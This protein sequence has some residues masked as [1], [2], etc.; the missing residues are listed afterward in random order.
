MLGDLE[1]L[2]R[3]SSQLLAYCVAKKVEQIRLLASFHCAYARAMREPTE[4]NIAAQRSALDAVLSAGGKVGSSLHI[5]NLVEVSLIAG[6]WE[7]AEAD[8]AD[9]FAFV[10]QSGERYW[11]AD[12]HRLRGQ[13]ALKQ[14]VPDRSRAE[15]CF[16]QAIDIARRQDARLLELRAATDLAR[17][18]RDVRADND[19]HALLLP[20]LSAIEGGETARDVRNARSLLDWP[21]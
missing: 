9:G 19:L 20:I 11:L 4:R 6:H 13:L 14:P 15:A 17:L 5:S 2:E 16:T 21:S 8:L 1:G 12:L 18:W 3:D 10:E 7:R